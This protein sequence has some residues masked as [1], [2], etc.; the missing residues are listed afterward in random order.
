MSDLEL[1]L[2]KLEREQKARREAELLLEDKSRELFVTNEELRRLN[3]SL[4]EQ[5]QRRTEELSAAKQLAR[6]DA[7]AR[8]LAEERFRA[9]VESAP[10]AMV[11]IDS[12]GRIVLAN[13]EAHR[14]F[15]FE[16]DELLG[17]AVEILIPARFQVDHPQLRRAFFDAPQPRRMGAGR[18]LFGLRKDGNEFPI[19]IGLN[20]VETDDGMFVLSAIVDITERK[21]RAR[22]ATL[23]HRVTAIAAAAQ[24]FQAI[25]QDT[26]NAICEIVEWPIGHV[27]GPDDG[28]NSEL[29]STGIWYLPDD[30]RFDSFRSATERCRFGH[31]VGLPGR[32]LASGSP[33]WIDDV[34]TDT[35]YPRNQMLTDLPVHGAFAFPVIVQGATIAVLEFYHGE[36]ISPDDS[37]LR[38]TANIG[39]QLGQA[40]ERINSRRDLEEHARELERSNRELQEFAYVASHDLKSPLRAILH[41]AQ[42]IAKDE[43]NHLSAQSREDLA[44]L[45]TR[46][47]AM[48]R[49][50]DDLLAYSRV[51]RKAYENV[52]IN[53]GELI[54][55]IIMSLDKPAEFEVV[56]SDRM[57]TLIAPLVPLRLVLQNLM[58]NAIKHHDQSDGHMEISA[59]EDENFVEF[60]VQDDG[61]GIPS[62]AVGKVFEI[63]VT[64]G[65]Q[66]KG[67][68]SGMGLALVKK[69]VETH[70]G[71][72]SIA[73]P[74]GNRGVIFHVRWPKKPLPR[75][76][77]VKAGSQAH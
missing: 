46:S 51:G 34:G 71:S 74:V 56:V 25:L 67:E 26:V 43:D 8:K 4:E 55:D 36:K 47:S 28:N 27:F 3:D 53:T 29:V 22:E 23:L 31:G 61:P 60:E 41:L 18:D 21:R 42:W 70:G 35:N 13:A 77:I 7:E 30:P 5:V 48:S 50:L 54:A 49:L 6:E 39:S 16:P 9:T 2:K 73:T 33:A 38:V 45:Q 17:Q 19:E 68:A 65:H 32:V 12:G 62:D 10:T 72:V 59:S 14:M 57:P 75:H 76:Q 40:F 20:P 1:L 52:E 37:L 15:Q 44:S 66:E 24:S 11:M 63:F 69:T 58:E 64:L